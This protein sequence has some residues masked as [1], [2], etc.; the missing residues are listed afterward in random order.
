MTAS[1]AIVL[2]HHGAVDDPG[3]L[4]PAVIDVPDP[5]AGQVRVRVRAVALNHL[6]IW[7]RRG[8]PGLKLTYPHRL[9]SDIVGEVDAVGDGVTHVTPG[10]RVVVAPGVSCGVCERCLG[11]EDNLCPKYHI[12]GESTNGGYIEHINVPA[13]NM[14]PYPGDLPYEQVA[15]V[16][17]TF[18]T[19]WQMVVERAKVRP[20]EL[21]LVQGAGSGV[22][23]AAIQIARLH[24][25]RVWAT[26]G[27]DA[28]C[29][30]ALA[31]GAERAINYTTHD[32]VAEVRTQ[33][34]KRGVDVVIEHVGGETFT[35]S[36]LAAGRGGR[37]VTCGATSGFKPEIDLRQIFFR[38]VQVLGS[39]MGRRA[40]L[41]D[42]LRHV[43]R[44]HLKP[45]V[46][47][48]LPLAEAKTAHRVLEGREAFGKVVL[49][50]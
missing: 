3:V 35:R 19:A 29:E 18:L 6:D 25:A 37:V 27:S 31:L 17:L 9:G 46:D 2:H 33:T 20:G 21:V 43:E 40:T 10:Q 13:A 16:P 26:A 7:V 22:G 12:L 30:R 34:N 5:G 8:L 36:I 49:T 4:E 24:G 45:V 32:F 48:V 39:T 23:V 41:F 11:G 42:I 44:G 28:K 14:L 1:R 50:V 15:A 38:N 47:R